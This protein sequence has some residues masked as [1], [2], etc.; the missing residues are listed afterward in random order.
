MCVCVCV[1]VRVCADCVLRATPP[2]RRPRLPI[3]QSMK[4]RDLIRAVRSCKTAAEERAMITKECALIRTSFRDESSE[5][6]HRNVAKLLFVH[7]LG[8]PTHFG[9]MECVKLIASQKFAEK[10]IGYL[11]RAGRR[12]AGRAPGGRP[13]KGGGRIS[14]ACRVAPSPLPSS[15]PLVPVSPALVPVF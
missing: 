7:M 12:L 6:R 4:L 3:P 2:P 8:Y 10:R 9:Q 14:H 1:C 5:F 15:V 13:G 11:V